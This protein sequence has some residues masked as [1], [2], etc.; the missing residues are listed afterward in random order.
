MIGAV[1]RTARDAGDPT[2]DAVAAYVSETAFTLLDRVVTFR[3]LEER[4]LLSSHP[5][6]T[7]RRSSAYEPPTESEALGSRLLAS[8]C[9]RRLAPYR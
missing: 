4:E 3:C 9:Q 7:R 6:G 1:I 8:T 5:A 2:E